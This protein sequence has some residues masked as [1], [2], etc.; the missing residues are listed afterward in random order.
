MHQWAGSRKSRIPEPGDAGIVSAIKCNQRINKFVRPPGVQ[1]R[2]RDGAEWS[3]SRQPGLPQ[4]G[5]LWLV[6]A[7]RSDVRVLDLRLVLIARKAIVYERSAS[8]HR[9]GRFT[10]HTCRARS[11]CRYT[12]SSSRLGR[13]GP[14]EFSALRPGQF[15]PDR[16]NPRYDFMLPLNSP[17]DR[18]ETVKELMNGQRAIA[19]RRHLEEV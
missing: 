4:S 14:S 13:F 11:G 16:R 10:L 1:L 8:D 19:N 17:A 7:V 5:D 15:P 18:R 12:E 6:S 2:D 3:G 9:A